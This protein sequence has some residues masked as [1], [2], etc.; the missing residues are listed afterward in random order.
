MELILYEHVHGPS[1]AVTRNVDADKVVFGVEI[2]FPLPSPAITIGA[3]PPATL[4]ASPA[5]VAAPA[6]AE[7]PVMVATTA[8]DPRMVPAAVAGPAAGPPAVWTRRRWRSGRLAVAAV[9]PVPVDG[10]VDTAA[11]DQR[12]RQRAVS[13]TEDTT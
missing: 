10:G 9:P 5:A 3:G 6:T 1:V 4:S 13:I 2:I 11:P 8:A 12:R 7:A